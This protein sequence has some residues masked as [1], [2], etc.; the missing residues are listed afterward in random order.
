MK[1]YYFFV[2]PTHYFMSKY[3]TLL[4]FSRYQKSCTHTVWV[5]PTGEIHEKNSK[6]D[7]EV[8]ERVLHLHPLCC[9]GV[10]LCATSKSLASK[11]APGHPKDTSP[12][13]STQ[14]RSTFTCI[15]SHANFQLIGNQGN[16]WQ[17][18]YYCFHHLDLYSTCAAVEFA[19]AAC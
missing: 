5:P 8:S 16:A 12:D 11:A 14:S 3:K 18:S 15:C 17:S 19:G 9:F 1:I 13:S 10:F 6:L 4:F 2:N 7:T